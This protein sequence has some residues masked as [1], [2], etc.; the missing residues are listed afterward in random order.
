MIEEAYRNKFVRVFDYIEQHLGDELFVE[1]LSRDADFSKFHFH[2]QFSAYVGVNVSRYVQIR[3]LARAFRRL[4]FDPDE[5][6]IDVAYEAGIQTP[7]SFSRAFKREYGQT[8]SQFRSAPLWKPWCESN[9]FL[10][11]ERRESMDVKIVD[12]TE[13][14]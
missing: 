1:G 11:S 2:R 13:M 10:S 8:P 9:Q 12:F 6:I 7:E 4:V 5:K 14:K 3:R